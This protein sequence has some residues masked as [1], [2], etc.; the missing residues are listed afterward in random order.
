M[1]GEIHGLLHKALDDAVKWGLVARN[2]CDLVDRPHVE[3][4]ERPCLLWADWQL[5]QPELYA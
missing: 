5:F 3:K 4:K 1:V 2:V